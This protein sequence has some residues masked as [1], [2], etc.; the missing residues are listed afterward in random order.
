M[1]NIGKI[2][3]KI[4]YLKS[5]KKLLLSQCQRYIEHFLKK[6]STVYYQKQDGKKLSKCNF[7]T[8][9]SIY[10]SNNKK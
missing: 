4:Q 5:F 2:D 7:N 1:C 6:T 3:I 9:L 8:F 10:Y